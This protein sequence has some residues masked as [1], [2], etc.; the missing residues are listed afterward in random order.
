MASLHASAEKLKRR[1]DFFFA[2]QSNPMV[3][4]SESHLWNGISPDLRCKKK[5]NAVTQ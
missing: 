4:P 5:R 3:L 1:R 2:L